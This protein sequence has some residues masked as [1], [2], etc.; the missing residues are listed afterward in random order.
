MSES[1]IILDSA[2]QRTR[3]STVLLPPEPESSVGFFEQAP[4]SGIV[5]K[6]RIG[7]CQT[8]TQGTSKWSRRKDTSKGTGIVVASLELTE[9]NV[10]R[11]WSHYKRNE[12]TGCLEW[13]GATFD[14]Y[15]RF[16]VKRNGKSVNYQSH[17]LAFILINGYDPL[18]LCVCHRCDN[19][20]CGEPSH[21]FPGTKLENTRDAVAK[22]RHVH[23][24]TH[25]MR[26]LEPDQVREIRSLATSVSRYDLADR[27]GVTYETIARIIRREGWIG[28][29]P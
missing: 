13:V 26:K 10:A 7:G 5:D 14:G 15:G 11:F 12:A 4:E 9:N 21:L 22:G 17:K 28:V 8:T 24:G 20:L 6:T 2:K 25:G 19:R 1:G 18:P 3:T 29:E 23:A 27:F 16:A